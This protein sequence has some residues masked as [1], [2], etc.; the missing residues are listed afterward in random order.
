MYSIKEKYPQFSKEAQKYFS[1]FLVHI[2][3][4]PNFL[5]MLNQNNISQTEWVEK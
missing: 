2:C 5:N 3:V 1:I 4:K